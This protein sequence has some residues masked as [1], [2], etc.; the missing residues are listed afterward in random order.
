[1]TVVSRTL[2]LNLP[3]D[4]ELSDEVQD[5][6]YLAKRNVRK[7]KDKP[8]RDRDFLLGLLKSDRM[9]TRPTALLKHAGSS[10]RQLANHY[11]Q[12]ASQHEGYSQEAAVLNQ[13]AEIAK[14]EAV[15]GKKPRLEVEHLLLA[16]LESPDP[17]VQAVFKAGSLTPDRVKAALAKV[18]QE[19]PVR[20]ALYVIRETVEVVAVVVFLI[21]LI[22][23]GL[24]EVR[25]IPSES[26]VPT[27]QIGDRIV[28]ERVSHWLGQKPQRGDVL[29]FYPPEPNAI[30]RHDPWSVFLRLTGFSGLIYSK[31][32]GIDTAYIKRTVGLPGDIVEVRPGMGVL[33]NGKLLNEPYVNEIAQT[34]T[35]Q[36]LCGPVQVPDG[37]YYMM[38]DNRNHSA[39]S[40]VWQFLPADRIIGK[41]VFRFFPFDQ[42][43]GPLQHPV[44]Q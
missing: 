27:L 21:V 44:Y 7:Q 13:A 42:R 2:P 15:P 4:V 6:V 5:I 36:D 8:L 40:R 41:A 31:E 22:R 26:M 11:S 12:Y 10:S 29:V 24:G 32:S 39:D 34:C 20:M 1:M 35:F 37:M 33:V 17:A 9:F 16:L 38:G 3:A 43:F 23:Q 28:V 18:E 19:S 30:L 14:A 25:L